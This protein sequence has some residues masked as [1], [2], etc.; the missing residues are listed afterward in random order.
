MRQECVK[1]AARRGGEVE[2][3][4][5]DGKFVSREDPGAAHFSARA[6][7]EAYK[8]FPSKFSPLQTHVC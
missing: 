2:G 7:L 6:A 8:R 5:K 4:G 1:A 3:G